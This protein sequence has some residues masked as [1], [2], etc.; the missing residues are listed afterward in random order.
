MN[1]YIGK[2]RVIEQY[3]LVLIFMSSSISEFL[4]MLTKII[5]ELQHQCVILPTGGAAMQASASCPGKLRHVNERSSG[6]NCCPCN[7]SRATFTTTPYLNNYLMNC[8]EFGAQMMRWWL[9]RYRLW[10]LCISISMYVDPLNF[11]PLTWIM[12]TSDADVDQVSVLTNH[13]FLICVCA[14]AFSLLWKDVK[15]I[16]GKFFHRPRL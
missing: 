12:S 1:N 10:F 3:V 13:L 5:C 14:T 11:L 9:F 4:A 7:Q 8:H 16:L 6:S 2:R 15:K